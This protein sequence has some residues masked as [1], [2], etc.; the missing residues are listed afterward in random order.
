MPIKRY[1]SI[2]ALFLCTIFLNAQVQ[3]TLEIYDLKSNTRSVVLSEPNHFEAPNWSKDG[4]YLIVNG[5]GKLYKID[6][7]TKKKIQIPTGSISL[8][9]NDHGISPDG[10]TLAISGFDNSK[11]DTLFLMNEQWKRSQIFVLPIDGGEPTLITNNKTS[12]WH[13]W[14]PDGTKMVYT[15]KRDSEEFDIYKIEVESKKETQL[16]HKNGH[17]DGPEFSNDGK[18]IYYN[19]METGSMEIW[20]M[21]SDGTNKKQLT[22]DNHSNWFPH[23]SP[24][25]DVLVYLAFIEDQGENH[26]PM[27]E[28]ALKLFDLHSGTITT[29]FTFTGGQG[30]INV[31]SWSPTGD[32]FAFVSYKQLYKN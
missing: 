14:S 19:S 22:N 25:R 29:L 30:T 20:K 9:N 8:V 3:S 7:E 26:P 2:S 27:K 31:P 4:S 28:V 13:G 24:I 23:P 18:Y 21:E 17:D 1:L 15:A 16:T 12:F 11:T 5:E 10:K 6:L 32:K